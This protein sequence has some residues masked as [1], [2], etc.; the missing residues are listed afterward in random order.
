VN[1][2]VIILTILINLILESTIIPSFWIFE[3]SP[4]TGLIIVVVLAIL[5][6]KTTGAI[7]GL[8]VGLLQDLLFSPVIGINSFIYF[9]I[10]YLVGL[11]ET[12]LSKDNI[13]LPILMTILSTFGYHLTYYLFMYFL[14][15]NEHLIKFFKEVALMEILNN[16][17]L[18][19]PVFKLLS[20]L[21]VAPTIR[22]G[23]K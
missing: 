7:V 18:S 19:I 4:S 14:N 9:F 17:I 5:N 13:L 3:V 16:S 10:G 1:A 8:I 21:F 22:F 11:A 2:F 15:Y 23:K 12:K 6:G 20:K